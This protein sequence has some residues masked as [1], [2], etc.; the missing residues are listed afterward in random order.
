MAA[1]TAGLHFT[2]KVLDDLA[3]KNIEV[4]KVTL[5]V[6]AGTFKPIENTLESHTIEEEEYTVSPE[7]A[8][9]HK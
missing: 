6:G 2:P 3:A 7:T 4:V 9:S 8:A 5:H 1:P